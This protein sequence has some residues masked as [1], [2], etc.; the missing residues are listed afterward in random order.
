[1]A[2]NEGSYVESYAESE[3]G[4]EDTRHFG[5]ECAYPEEHP[6]SDPGIDAAG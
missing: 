5:F 4:H 6:G 1:M 3:E 2:T